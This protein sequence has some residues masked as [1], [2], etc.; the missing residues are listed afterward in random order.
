MWADC[1]R[2]SAWAWAGVVVGGTES[3]EME[4]RRW[5]C[6]KQRAVYGDSSLD[7]QEG[8]GAVEN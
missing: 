4:E 8:S 2:R 3:M 6:S 1:T 7:E 5:A